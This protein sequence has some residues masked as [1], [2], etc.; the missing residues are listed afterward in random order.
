MMAHDR[1]RDAAKIKADMQ[2][3]IEAYT[4]PITKCAPGEANAKPMGRT[5][6]AARWLRSHHNDVP[7]G[8]PEAERKRRA[9]RAK[10]K[11]KKRMAR[12]GEDS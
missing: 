10:R 1:G 9:E 2:R 3:A 7:V 11:W 12:R 8:D 5:D 4:G 6:R